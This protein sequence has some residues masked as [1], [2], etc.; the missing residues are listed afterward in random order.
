MS[1]FCFS[2]QSEKQKETIALGKHHN[3][4][5]GPSSTG[6]GETG[7]I[8]DGGEFGSKHPV[9]LGG[10]HISQPGVVTSGVET[11]V[12]STRDKFPIIEINFFVP[13]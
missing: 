3:P 8:G 5:C 1:N 10:V 2:R 7:T 9:S 6:T 4:D 13:A 12:E 11:I